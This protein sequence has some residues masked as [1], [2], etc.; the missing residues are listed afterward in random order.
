MKTRNSLVA[1]FLLLGA[2]GGT[3]DRA[4]PQE[5]TGAPDYSFV[6]KCQD[7]RKILENALGVGARAETA[8]QEVAILEHAIDRALEAG[9]GRLRKFY[10]LTLSTAKT[11]ASLYSADPERRAF[12]LR[13]Y[14][15]WALEDLTY[16]D[17]RWN[18]NDNGPYVRALLDRASHVGYMARRDS[19]EIAFLTHAFRRALA[20][21]EDSDYRRT[22]GYSCG[23]K[24]LGDALDA[25]EVP[26]IS[27]D[28]Q[29]T[30]LRTA[31]FEALHSLCWH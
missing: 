2:L 19:E 4:Y 23:A 27:P 8:A 18:R 5:T 25:I 3:T 10:E 12:M 1:L 15:G 30:T 29:I 13:S 24:V 16:F 26:G 9:Q 7:F 31:L 11:D 21:L 22:Q 20:L 14:I 6:K 17:G 28:L